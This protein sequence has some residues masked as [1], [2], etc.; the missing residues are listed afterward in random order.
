M[1]WY[2]Y[3]SFWNSKFFTIFRFSLVLILII[4]GIFFPE[5]NFL[6]SYFALLLFGGIAGLYLNEDDL[7]SYIGTLVSCVFIAIF[8]FLFES[9]L[10]IAN[11]RMW[12]LLCIFSG[13]YLLVINISQTLI[14]KREDEEQ[15]KRKASEEA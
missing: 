4:R 9:K 5:S 2:Y 12:A 1:D 3:K 13:L 6:I 15:E 7:L 10:V 11:H 14:F 8:F